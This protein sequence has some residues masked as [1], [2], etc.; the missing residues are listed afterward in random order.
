M[1]SPGARAA[2]VRFGPFEL[3]L[4]GEQLR[5]NGARIRIQQQPFLLLATLV[6]SPG[7]IVTREELRERLWP[8]GTFVDFEHGLN[9]A[10]KK[11]R[12]ALHDSTDRP[13]YVETVRGRG[14]R[15][16]APV[17]RVDGHGADTAGPTVPSGRSRKLWLVVAGAA[18]AV[19]V[20]VVAMVG[21]RRTEGPS[22]P[23][24]VPLTSYPGQEYEP[25][26]SP[27]GSHVAFVWRRDGADDIYVQPVDVPQ[28]RPLADA[29]EI[30]HSPAWS[31]DGRWIAFIRDPAEPEGMARVLLKPPAGGPERLVTEYPGSRLPLSRQ[32]QLAWTPDARHLVLSR[33]DE[34]QSTWS[35]FRVDVS[36]GQT[37]PLT[38]S[39]ER[40]VAPAVSPD[41]RT[42]TFGRQAGERGTIQLL[43]LSPEAGAAGPVR[44][45]VGPDLLDELGLL[46]CHMPAWTP[47]GQAVV[48]A[49]YPPGPQLYVVN[50]SGTPQVV[51]VPASEGALAD[52]TFC[53]RT[54]RLAY[55]LW[56]LSLSILRL[57]LRPGGTGTPVPAAF[58]STQSDLRPLFSPD[59]S[60]VAF[61][62]GRRGG[63]EIWLSHPDGSGQRP[64]ASPEEGWHWELSWSPDGGRIAYAG[65]IESNIDVYI[66]SV[67]GSRKP[68]RLT[69]DPGQDREPCWSPDGLWIY[70][71]STRDGRRRI[72]RMPAEGGPPERVT[73]VES[74]QPALSAD[75]RFLYFARGWPTA[76]VSV[77]RMPTTGGKE[78][79]VLES[80]DAFTSW[81][82]TREGIYFFEPPPPGNRP[83]LFF[84]DLASSRTRRVAIVDGPL[85]DGL[86]VS[87]DGKT[88][89][90]TRHDDVHADLMLRG[91]P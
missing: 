13:R 47:D 68:L 44:T 49:A 25:T 58:N 84:H 55:A 21:S 80:V 26:F 57:D 85:A 39:P 34:G 2:L 79:R 54:G 23:Q 6:E 1:G 37:T 66:A 8:D 89:F 41:G 69:R 50:V 56:R 27:D 76:S 53:P 18:G 30:E 51:R 75:G 59:G 24:V 22:A 36:S 28:P 70:F 32:R 88:L 35:L 31:P 14:Y 67:A 63:S 52:M 61:V 65:E 78:E 43:P 9:T 73:E 42:L 12:L 5:R 91:W 87:R 3:D 48:F 38:T 60:T 17:T 33:P 45:L 71:T 46:T 20:L 7:E 90:F 74:S 16:L 19:V 29:P 86:T 4:Q 64:L 10:V 62:S 83:T 81:R 77:W 72:W 15:F 40:D 11:I 82:L